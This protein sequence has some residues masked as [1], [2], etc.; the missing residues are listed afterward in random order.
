MQVMKRFGLWLF[1]ALLQL[2]LFSFATF[3]AL[4]AVIGNPDAIKGALQESGIYQASLSTTL[5]ASL[6]DQTGVEEGTFDVSN[7]LVSDAL[8][9]ALT[10]NKMQSS[11]EKAID[12]IYA[13]L[14]GETAYPDFQIDFEQE[15][16]TFIE[17]IADNAVERVSTLPFCSPDQLQNFQEIDPLTIECR[18]PIDLQTQ[19]QVVV[20]QLQNNANFLE[21]TTVEGEQL[22][23]EFKRHDSAGIIDKLP[24]ATQLARLLPWVSLLAAA[25]FTGSIILLSHDR[26]R[27]FR[28]IA[29]VLLTTGAL[30]VIIQ[31][32]FLFLVS[33]VEAQGAFGG[34]SDT[35][36]PLVN[37]LG[38]LQ[39]KFAKP[40]LA[41]AGTY[42]IVGTGILLYLRSRK[43]EPIQPPEVSEDKKISPS[44]DL[45]TETQDNQINNTQF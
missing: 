36:Q 25:I 43:Q 21:D 5:T 7:P 41:V 23:E 37:F 45:P 16:A 42:L 38:E 12:G 31:L 17:A 1:V 39:W 6:E 2:S 40:M 11:V 15:K 28:K 24:Q 19:R 14:W 10:E 32:L 34:A 3:F 44:E 29:V 20:S 30:L 35:N 22:F 8:D 9:T 33:Q 13:W 27:D 4:N 18:P 26:R